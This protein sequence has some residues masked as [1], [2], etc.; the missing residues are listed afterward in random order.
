MKTLLTLL[1]H[2]AFWKTPKK[3]TTAPLK[4]YET[5]LNQSLLIRVINPESELLDQALGITEARLDELKDALEKAINSHHGKTLGIPG[6]LEEITPV[7]KH[8]NEIIYVG[9]MLGAWYEQNARLARIAKMV[10]PGS[11]DS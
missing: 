10:N 9:I 8:P 2:L 3:E 1:S 11:K 5:D 4:T 7:L 6:A